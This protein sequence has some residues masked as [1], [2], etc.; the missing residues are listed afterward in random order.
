MS[1]YPN[2]GPFTD[3][4][5]SGFYFHL[6]AY[7]N[8]LEFFFN[9]GPHIIFAQTKLFSKLK[10]SCC[11]QEGGQ[12]P[13]SF[14]KCCCPLNT[15]SPDKWRATGGWGRGIPLLVKVTVTPWRNWSQVAKSWSGSV[16]NLLW[17]LWSL[18]LLSRP[19]S[20]SVKLKVHTR[21]AFKG[22]SNWRIER[23]AGKEWLTLK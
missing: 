6:C 10:N 4:I 13:S 19:V 7:L 15:W 11:A 18:L 21:G 20:F 23:K 22:P 9:Y 14:Q 8:W 1:I 2:N 12:L 16:I 5:E 17:G 3:S